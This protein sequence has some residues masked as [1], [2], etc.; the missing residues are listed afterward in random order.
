MPLRDASLIRRGDRQ[1]VW[2]LVRDRGALISLFAL[3]PGVHPRVR[4]DLPGRS[5]PGA[6]AARRDLVR[7]VMAA[8]R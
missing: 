8:G 1:D 4:F 3:P 5:G 2:L 6:A 7:A